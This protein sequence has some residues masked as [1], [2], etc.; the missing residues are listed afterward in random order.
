MAKAKF[1][2]L[3]SYREYP[4][5]QMR[6]RAAAFRAQMQRRRSV[7][8]FSS[9]PVEREVIEEC[10]LAAGSA[11][12]GANIQPW[13]FV[14][15]SDPQVKQRLREAAEEA[16]YEFYHD[17]ASDEWLDALSPL[18][19]NEQKPFLET[20]PYLIAIFAQ[21]YGVLADGRKR[22]HCYVRNSVGIATG[23]LIAAIHSAGLVCLPYTPSRVD[24]LSRILD[25]PDNE[26][27][28]LILVVGYPAEGARVPDIGKKPLAET[29]TFV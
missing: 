3:T 19:T 22:K 23:I 17:K 15:V 13:S 20:A 21:T 26:Q 29:A 7:R 25:R 14:V 8:E 16:E 18:G 9:R 27:P 4:P 28:F 11:P 1:V 12:S 24:F 10:L 6:E 5:E 2:P